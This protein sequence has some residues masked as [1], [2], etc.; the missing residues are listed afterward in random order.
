[1]FSTLKFIATG[2]LVLPCLLPVPRAEAALLEKH[3]GDGGYI[4]TN[5]APSWTGGLYVES[6]KDYYINTLLGRG[7]RPSVRSTFAFSGTK[8]IQARVRSGG[9]DV[10][11]RSEVYLV[12]PNK[13]YERQTRFVGFAVYVPSYVDYTSDRWVNFMQVQHGPT[14]P[15]IALYPE[16]V[17]G[18]KTS[19]RLRLSLN[20]RNGDADGEKNQTNPKIGV[21]KKGV[22]NQFVI[23]ARMDY[24]DNGIA[25]IHY[26]DG[27]TWKIIHSYTGPLGN[28]WT[29]AEHNDVDV[30]YGVYCQ[31]GQFDDIE[32]Y[33]DNLRFATTL[34]EAKP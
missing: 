10:K 19:Y 15:S 6:G 30:H 14:T 8:S 4:T 5:D 31:G 11:S 27:T 22:W 25:K 28:A 12:N 16:P 32:H 13:W 23:E 3:T 1:M 17:S 26:K 33:F 20:W 9:T 34:D 7:D 21:F 29:K 18:D 2:L 24:R